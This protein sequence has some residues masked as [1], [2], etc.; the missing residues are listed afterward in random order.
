[1]DQG[2]WRTQSMGPQKNQHDWANNKF[3]VRLFLKLKVVSSLWNFYCSVV[4]LPFTA[5]TEYFRPLSH[6]KSCNPQKYI[7]RIFLSCFLLLAMS[8]PAICNPG[9]PILYRPQGSTD[10]D[11]VLGNPGNKRTQWLCMSH[12]EP[13]LPAPLWFP[14][15]VARQHPR[16]FGFLWPTPLPEVHILPPLGPLGSTNHCCNL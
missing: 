9:D 13:P 6:M 5:Q 3:L 1:M 10:K 8:S 16:T 4:I 12:L 15:C 7:F 14:V 11:Q 2:T